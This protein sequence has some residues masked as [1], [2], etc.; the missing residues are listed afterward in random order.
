MRAPM[1]VRMEMVANRK[2]AWTVQQL[3]SP[4]MRIGFVKRDKLQGGF[5]AWKVLKE[6]CVASHKYS[7]APNGSIGLGKQLAGVYEHR[8]LYIQYMRCA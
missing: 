1:G 7:P 4:D 8:K 2:R 3:G 5:Y 6:R